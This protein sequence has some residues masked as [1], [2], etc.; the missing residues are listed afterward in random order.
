[1]L[2][3]SLGVI[4]RKLDRLLAEEERRVG[5]RISCLSLDI[6]GTIGAAPEVVIWAAAPEPGS[7][8]DPTEILHT[9]RAA[10]RA[11]VAAVVA[12]AR[13]VSARRRLGPPLIDERWNAPRLGLPKRH[14]VDTLGRRIDHALKHLGA[15][16]LRALSVDAGDPERT[17][18]GLVQCSAELG[19]RRRRQ[20]A[21]VLILLH[22]SPRRYDRAVASS[23]RRAANELAT[24]YR[25][26]FVY[27]VG[28][29]P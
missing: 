26:R 12:W 10:S 23:V 27:R 2:G 17:S 19:S 28:S 21:E 6:G 1:M 25:A 14:V 16:R 9:Y 13:S 29:A 22:E 20:S 7:I 15:D 5:T 24:H 11:R 3:W 8:G 18:T 4:A